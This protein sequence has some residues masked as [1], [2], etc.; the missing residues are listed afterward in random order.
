MHYNTESNR[1]LSGLNFDEKLVSE[2][3]EPASLESR[4]SK[5]VLFKEPSSINDISMEPESSMQE[6]T[7]ELIRVAKELEET[8]LET[9]WVKHKQD[10]TKPVISK[11]LV[12][13]IGSDTSVEHQESWH[14]ENGDPEKT[15]LE[16]RNNMIS[17]VGERLSHIFDAKP[18]S[19]PN[20][21][22]LTEMLSMA[23][24]K[25]LENDEKKD[26]KLTFTIE[27]TKPLFPSTDMEANLIE[28]EIPS[29]EYKDDIA[30]GINLA[31]ASICK[32]P[33]TPRMSIN[34]FSSFEPQT[35][36]SSGS[37]IEDE[38]EL[39]TSR[40][41][42]Q[43]QLLAETKD[44]P[45]LPKLPVMTLQDYKTTS[46]QQANGSR[47]FSVAT[48]ADNYQSAKEYDSISNIGTD[49]LSDVPSVEDLKI[50]DASFSASIPTFQ[51]SPGSLNL[52]TSFETMKYDKMDNDSSDIEKLGEPDQNEHSELSDVDFIENHKN[53]EIQL[54][55]SEHSSAS[56]E[57]SV[58]YVELETTNDS[59]M[60]TVDVE[61][62]V[63]PISNGLF[64][65]FDDDLFN[66]QEISQ[67]SIDITRSLRN[68]NY[69]SIWHLQESQASNVSPAVSSNSQF[70]SHSQ[71]SFINNNKSYQ[72]F[73]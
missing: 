46:S 70:S 5:S 7:E 14:S 59:F 30:D 64:S 9:A 31:P 13:E 25:A 44:A 3:S 66:D 20:I 42:D 36:T 67:D 56:E 49:Q 65:L 73:I 72:Q 61:L 1:R 8:P 35:R 4:S 21:P 43:Y 39:N 48:T 10:H 53:P 28:V 2:I 55:T 45:T 32:I 41:K 19:N 24:E 54:A 33:L 51:L 62:P 23:D 27:S 57:H 16:I 38:Q 34:K 63:L 37:S 50:P 22:G 68:N 40:M 29:N 60:Q 47:I 17:D 11:R 52:S 12:S 6:S 58:F 26:E 18:T 69:L 15:N 71:A